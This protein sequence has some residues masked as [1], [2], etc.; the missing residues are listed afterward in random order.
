VVFILRPTPAVKDA[1]LSAFFGV[2]KN[3]CRP[4]KFEAS[5]AEAVSDDSTMRKFIARV[6]RAEDFLSKASLIA[7]ELVLD[8]TQK[9]DDIFIDGP[10]GLYFRKPTITDALAKFK[11][12]GL[13]DGQSLKGEKLKITASAKDKGLEQM[14]AVS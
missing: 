7:G 5:L 6:P 2:C 3:I 11:I 14:V 1:K 12:D 4:A 10:D 13:A 8:L 9:C